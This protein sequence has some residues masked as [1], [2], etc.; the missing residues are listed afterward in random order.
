MVAVV[1]PPAAG[2]RAEIEGAAVQWKRTAEA[3]GG[4]LALF[5]QELPPGFETRPRREPDRDAAIY[6][7]A[8]E[9]LLVG[10]RRLQRV[11]A[12]GFAWIPRG[13][14][15]RYMNASEDSSARLLGFH[16]PATRGD[17]DHPAAAPGRPAMQAFV[18]A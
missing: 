9:I 18:V 13:E 10:E 3:S 7:L 8:G 5:E 14:R 6:V 16:A 11:Q 2:R 4:T 17:I 15:H 12:G 1:V